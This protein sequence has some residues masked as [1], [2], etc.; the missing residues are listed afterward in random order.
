MKQKC[1]G[2]QKEA[3]GRLPL[4]P[5]VINLDAQEGSDEDSN[6]NSAPAKQSWVWTH[7]C[8]TEDG[9]E[10]V[11]QVLGNRKICGRM[12]KKDQSGIDL[13]DLAIYQMR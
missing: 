2:S 5:E 8:E 3:P 1:T 10:A 9:A 6:P 7:F 13:V 11:C 4:P 12:I